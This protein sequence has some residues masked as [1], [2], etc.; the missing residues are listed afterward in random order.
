ML[1]RLKLPAAAFIGAL[2]MALCL[3]LA[4]TM[5][6]PIWIEK[7]LNGI[8]SELSGSKNVRCESLHIDLFGAELTKLSIGQGDPPPLLFESCSLK[9]N[10][11]SL[12][13]G[14]IARLTLSGLDVNMAA[15]DGKLS[16]QGISFGERADSGATQQRKTKIDAASILA[17][18]GAMP[19]SIACFEVRNAELDIEGNDISLV[20]PFEMTLRPKDENWSMADAS[21]EISP[22]GQRLKAS[23][24]ASK[25]GDR[26]SARI[27]TPKEIRLESIPFGYM[28]P[29]GSG[30]F[31]RLT[32]EASALIG[33]DQSNVEEIS[34]D[35][36]IDSFRLRSGQFRLSSPKDSP[37]TLKFRHA[38][39]KGSLEL[40]G[41]KIG[42][43]YQLEVK[44]L[45]SVYSFENG[46]LKANSGLALANSGEG[47]ILKAPANVLIES[48]ATFKGQGRRELSGTAR[49]VGERTSLELDF[50][51]VSCSS[52]S[53][54]VE[55]Q[56]TSDGRTTDFNASVKLPG[57]KVSAQGFSA[58]AGE[59]ALLARTGGDGAIDFDAVLSNTSFKN[60]NISAS[61]PKCDAGGRYKDGDL[62]GEASFNDASAS[63]AVSGLNLKGMDVRLPFKLP[64]PEKGKP[65]SIAVKSI[66]LKDLPI[67]SLSAAI[68]PAKDGLDI[69]GCFN[70]AK[71]QDLKLS[72]SS[73][74]RIGERSFVSNT[75]FSV[76]KFKIAAPFD[77]GQ[78][79]PKAK[80]T[81]LSGEF[82]LDGSYSMDWRGPSGSMTLKAKDVSIK[83]AAGTY[84]VD[85]LDASIE[86]PHLPALQSA[87]SQRISFKK[88]AFG[89]KLQLLEGAV[90]AR[91]DGPASIFVESFKSS[92]CGGKLRVQSFAFVPGASDYEVTLHCD[93]IS[94]A[95]FLDQL[96][97]GRAE[98]DGSIN[99]T[100]PLTFKKGEL[101]FQDAFLYSTPGEPGSLKLEDNGILTAGLQEGTPEYS[102]IDIAKE[103]LK[104]FSYTWT[105][106]SMNTQGD[107]LSIK[108]QLDGKPMS[109][110]PY[111]VEDGRYIRDNSQKLVFQG[112]RLDLNFNVPLSKALGLGG[113]FKSLLQQGASGQ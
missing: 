16:L 62:Q 77:L 36:N 95:Q 85:G 102:S 32:L 27:W 98:G 40:S 35:V 81:L 100:I 8:L 71:M 29:A 104:N 83:D 44:K 9:Y 72:F 48:T 10:P 73:S 58:E 52:S 38:Q 46:Q 57:I 4:A 17:E 49:L 105:K 110:L 53:P 55:F 64:L 112:I 14:K 109:P 26:I 3:Y 78:I 69:K 87:P 84:V 25:D 51:G 21:I 23:F 75:K 65:G 60:G 67:G 61:L 88:A 86:F 20:V 89:D 101:S 59:L 30:I 34:A 28:M 108:F 94:I 37:T 74:N 15:K 45:S 19:V 97:V 43:A 24:K 6:L 2:L 66:S 11:I 31:G 12:L 91:I 47:S 22:N 92:W 82:A 13:R 5:L 79:H 90:T 103:S 76:P 106:I 113:N 111:R 107:S 39:G 42:G 33:G 54:S 68:E 18:L 1:T 41:L 70:S 80:G 63:E 96:G 7:K 99:G 50:K 93:R 56:S